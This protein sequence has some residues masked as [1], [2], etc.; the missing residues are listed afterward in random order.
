[1]I[2]AVDRLLAALEGRPSDRIPVFCNL[3]D[4]GARELGVSLRDYYASGERVAE[5]QLR[6]RAR[7]GYDNLWSLFYVGKE[8][9]L[10]GDAEIVFADD[11]PPNVARHPIQS[12]E[13]IARLEIPRDLSTHP[14]FVEPLRC[15]RILRREAGGRQPICAYVTAS[16]TLPALAMGMERWMGLLLGGPAEVRDELLAKCSLLVQRELEL[17]R[18]EGVDVLLYASPFGTTDFLPH[19]LVRDLVMPWVERDLAPGGTRGVVYYGG[20]ARLGSVIELVQART[21]VGAFYLGP[22]DDIAAAKR[23]ASGGA[24]C[25]GVINDIRLIDDSPAT[26]R[27]EVARILA[28]GMPGGRFMFGTILMPYAIP[29]A[30]VRAMLDAAFELG[31]TAGP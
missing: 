27:A 23:A 8:A 28:A 10:F 6:M 17:Y 20:G 29:E 25:A 13:D 16:T 2:G 31:R 22:E 19:A 18:A 7:F 11:G 9:E 21:G 24:L 5:G 12:F 14:A 15:L 1:M 3:L 26:I 4:Q 30:N